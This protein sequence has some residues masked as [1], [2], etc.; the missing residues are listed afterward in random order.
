MRIAS[1]NHHPNSYIRSRRSKL[2]LKQLRGIMPACYLKRRKNTAKDETIQ[3]RIFS[4]PT[5]FI[6]Y[7]FNE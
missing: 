4:K 1:R 3:Q 5:K 6:S 2:E 7:A